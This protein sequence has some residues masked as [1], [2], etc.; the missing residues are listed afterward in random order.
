MLA[1]GFLLMNAVMVHSLL[2]VRSTTLLVGLFIPSYL[3]HT[4]LGSLPMR[5]TITSLVI[6][7]WILFLFLAPE[8]KY[9][10]KVVKAGGLGELLEDAPLM[11][12]L[13][14]LEHQTF[15]FPMYLFFNA[16]V[17]N[18]SIPL[19]NAGIG[20]NRQSVQDPR[21]TLHALANTSCRAV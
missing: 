4:S 17:W 6:W 9:S 8:R 11:T 19:T 21:K 10:A 20:H 1:S 18:G 16:S 2:K 12:A 15:G 14:L 7:K 3:S 13:S 5:V